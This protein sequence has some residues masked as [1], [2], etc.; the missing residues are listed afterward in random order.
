MKS[1]SFL[2]AVLFSLA[3]AAADGPHGIFPGDINAAGKPCDDFFDYAN[4]A[5]RKANPIPDYMDRWSRRWQSGELNKEHV[6]GI[7]DGVSARRDWPAGSAEQLS[8]D[9][10]GA[11]MDEGRINELAAGPVRPLLEEVESAKS[12]ADVERLIGR[13]HAIGVDV[14]FGVTADQDLHEPTR[15]I[16]HVY[17]GGLGMPD[18]DYY[19]KPDERFVEARA[20]YHEHVAKMFGLAGSEPEAANA[21]ATSV[22][23]LE[24]RL[25][26]ATLDIV[27]SRDPH[28][29]DHKTSFEGLSGMA[30]DFDWRAYFDAAKLPRVDL[31]VTEPKF[32]EAFNRELASAPIEQWRSYLA[33]HVLNTFAE[34]LSEPFVRQDFAF[35]GKYLSGAT[36]MKPRWKRCA[37]E[38][39]DQLGDAL[40]RAY[41]DKYFPP[42]A[43]ARMREM[44][45]YIQL[46]M[47]DTI[48]GLD[49]MSPETKA[50]ALEKL[51]TF[52]AKVGYPDRWKD[53]A[54]V[55]IGR[56][57]YFADVVAA[58]RWNIRD[59]LS[60]VGK[61]VD[62][63][64]WYMTPP[65]SNA[66]Y[67]ASMNEIVFPAGILQ[68]PAFDVTATDAV[69]YGAIGVV[70]GHEI[71]H[72]F[73]DQGAKFDAQGRLKNWWTPADQE[74]FEARGLCVV[75]QF[76]GYFIEPGIHHN[77]NLVLGESIGDLAGAKLAWLA[78]LKSREGKGPEPTIDGF[79]PAQQF[80]LSW[81]QWRGDETRPE[82]QRT[83][84]QTDPHPIAKYRVNGPL[85]NM[86]AFSEAFSCKAG[87]AMVRSKADRCEVW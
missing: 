86:P 56:E 14:G 26:E 74:E 77:G 15:M 38:T 19:L 33:W 7:L 49:W 28:Q 36:E 83:M 69:N 16:A 63:G 59:D 79:T 72:G 46:A 61:P 11:C 48:E 62:R 13:L 41:V 53:Y 5:W 57:S 9:F 29:Q 25:A 80:F 42:D 23:E 73:D 45:R 27:A 75:R 47:G 78:Y 44:V 58:T 31:N 1:R 8:G 66:Y 10:Y 55:T 12:R 6:R 65:T 2:V 68:P 18:R 50:R 76:E 43:K 51:G 39:D 52:N 17:A 21:A 87:D 20:K 4:G 71:S 24:R 82:T 30:P 40:G 32:L 3:A 37:E 22:F 34:S 35:Y 60:Q 54:G 64:R 67:S 85:S 70:I 81:G 84:V